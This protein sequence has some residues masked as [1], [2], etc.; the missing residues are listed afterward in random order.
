[1]R[2]A[3]IAFLLFVTSLSNAVVIQRDFDAF[4]IWM[5]CD[6]RGA[7]VFYYETVPDTGNLPRLDT[8]YKD[9][10][11]PDECQVATRGTYPR[12]IDKFDRGHLVPQNHFDHDV[13]LRRQ[14]NII[15]N[16]LP[17]TLTM[18]RA[19]WK[20]TEN[21]T[22]CYR[23]VTTLQVLGGVIWG[24]DVSN[25]HFVSTHGIATPDA[26]WK[27]IWSED[28]LIAWIVPNSH[29]ALADQLDSYIVSVGEIETR[30]QANILV[31]SIELRDI[32]P[33]TSWVLPEG[34][35]LK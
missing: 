17:Q 22:E 25:D 31:I 24:D 15:T 5:D 28:D 23:D 10:V 29:D 35:S 9:N 3:I 30:I 33:E 11:I 19:A 18:N 12:P 13:E 7:W 27:I 34:C 2:T 8:F 16:V 21:I 32:R 1:M 20:R 14:T 4:T 26:Y 6:V